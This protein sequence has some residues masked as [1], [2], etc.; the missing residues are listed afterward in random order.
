MNWARCFQQERIPVKIIGCNDAKKRYI[1]ASEEIAK[2][3]AINLATTLYKLPSLEDINTFI[4][5]AVRSLLEA[6]KP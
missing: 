5:S 6:P 3:T 1:Q 4:S 2:R